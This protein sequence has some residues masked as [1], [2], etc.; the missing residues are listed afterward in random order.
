M[1][2]R[3]NTFVLK[4]TYLIHAILTVFQQ[5]FNEHQFFIVII[6]F[7]KFCERFHTIFYIPFGQFYKRFSY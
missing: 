6:H 1:Y 7:I 3:F 4:Y 2:K 5:V